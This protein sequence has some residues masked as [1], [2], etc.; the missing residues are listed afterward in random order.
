MLIE[1]VKANPKIRYKI[2]KRFLE[3]NSNFI[4]GEKDLKI[5]MLT[6]EKGYVDFIL[7]P[8]LKQRE[9]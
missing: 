6:G 8:P 4:L 9:E 1:L 3:K 7:I 2:F 5:T